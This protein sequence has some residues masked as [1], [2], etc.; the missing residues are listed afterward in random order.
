MAALKV[1][2]M[3][4][5][6]ETPVAPSAGLLL[7]VVLWAQAGEPASTQTVARAARQAFTAFGRSRKR[8]WLWQ[9]WGFGWVQRFAFIR[10][11]GS[12]NGGNLAQF[13]VSSDCIQGEKRQG[14]P[15][16]WLGNQ[17]THRTS[18]Q[19]RSSQG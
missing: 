14:H 17:F 11:S 12:N 6:R 2:T 10:K 19:R 13:T 9:N 3:L 1:K 16:S 4:A 18:Q 5:E 15:L 8:E 7:T